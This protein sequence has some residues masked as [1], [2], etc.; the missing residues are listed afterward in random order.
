MG[1]GWPWVCYGPAP[2][3]VAGSSGNRASRRLPRHHTV[4]AGGEVVV[5]LGADEARAG[6]CYSE[7]AFS[8][9]AGC[10]YSAGVLPVTGN[11]VFAAC[12][13]E[14]IWPRILN[15]LA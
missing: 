7:S 3:V 14:L 13:G 8:R 5:A 11:A 4:V 10:D 6:I 2:V 12:G 15:A 9:G 1:A